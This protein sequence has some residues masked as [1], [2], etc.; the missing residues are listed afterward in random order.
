MLICYVSKEIIL[1]RSGSENMKMVRSATGKKQPTPYT[2]RDR[3]KFIR[4]YKL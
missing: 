4:P 2:S 3:P 1:L